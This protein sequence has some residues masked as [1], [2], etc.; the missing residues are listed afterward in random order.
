MESIVVV[1]VRD[2]KAS[3]EQLMLMVGRESSV[4]LP[5]ESAVI[6]GSSALIGRLVL[7]FGRESVEHRSME[8]PVVDGGSESVEPFIKQLVDMREQ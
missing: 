7:G 3:M 1:V 8:E 5:M 2:A 4:E 6:G